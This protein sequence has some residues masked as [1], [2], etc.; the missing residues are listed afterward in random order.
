M[1]LFLVSHLLDTLNPVQREAV[2]HTEGPLLILA[3]AGSGKTRVLTYRIAYLIQ[4]K[5]VPAWNILAVTFTNKAAN[6]M[7]ERVAALVGSEGKDVWVS[8]FH[9]FCARVLRVHAPLLGYGKNF[10]ILDPSDQTALMRTILSELNINDKSFPPATILGTIGRAKDELITPETYGANASDYYEQVVAS[11]YDLYQ[12]KLKRN[13]AMDFDDLI[14]MTVKLFREHPEVIETY[15]NR[16]KYI[17]V[18]EYQDTNHGQYV[19]INLLARKHKNICVVGDDDQCIV[20]DATVLTDAGPWRVDALSQGA[21]IIGAAGWNSTAPSLVGR[22]SKKSYQGPILHIFTKYGKDLRVTPNH[23]FF[24]IGDKS[25]EH[26]NVINLTMFGTDSLCP[27]FHWHSHSVSWGNISEGV[28]NEEELSKD[29]F[30][31]A[32]SLALKL[33]GVLPRSQVVEESKLTSG[34]PFSLMPASSLRVGMKIPSY[35]GNIV[36]DEILRID[37]QEYTGE[38]YDLYVPG[39]H[40]FIANGIVVHNSIYGWRGADIRNILDFEKDYNGTKVVR[41]EQNYRSTQTIL[42]AAN[43]VVANNTTRMRK[44]LWTQKG[45]GAEIFCYEAYNQNDEAFYVVN[46]IMNLKK[47]MGFKYG[48]MAVLYRTNAQSRTFEEELL[49]ANVKYKM[50]GGFKFYERKEIKDIISYLRLLV[51]PSDLVS[52][53]RIINVP[54]RG[55]GTISADKLAIYAEEK[56]ISILDACREVD[57][58]QGIGK[59]IKELVKSFSQMMQGFID[60][61]GEVGVTDLVQRVLDATGYIRELEAERT[62]EADGRVENLNELLTVTRS[63][64][65]RASNPKD[66]QTFLE[67]VALMTDIDKF[68]EEEDAV[69]L[70]TVHSAK[71][72]EFNVVF[73]VGLEEEIL[74]HKRSIYESVDGIEEERRLFYVAITRARERLYMTRAS[75]RMLYGA[76]SR[77]P[78]SRFFDEIP[79]GLMCHVEGTSYREIDVVPNFNTKAA[80]RMRTGKLKSAPSTKTSRTGFSPGDQ[81]RHSSWGVGTIVAVKGIGPKSEITVAFPN[82]GLKRLAAGIAPIERI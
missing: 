16:F 53:Q 41:L 63:F 18:D 59:K 77:N 8:T 2:E 23:M 69:T 15:Q 45:H 75:S 46:E 78:P 54:R 65:A 79:E 6:E 82:K 17:M 9:S 60:L 80:T 39:L 22:V 4:E 64:E 28:I 5:K 72:L 32:R 62:I 70:M 14:V 11:A 56:D 24:S 13:N 37:V 35:Q 38:V 43:A 66:L 26:E 29:E 7:K 74:P 71:G 34:K 57:E 10:V 52:F 47:N 81:V 67:E 21:I 58:I 36:E 30:L 1:V 12:K 55:I 73:I 68:D 31:D 25:S 44:K 50:I 19:L 49:K 61:L 40:N 33:S 48:D 20:S 27:Q 3:G 42:D 51:N 76:I